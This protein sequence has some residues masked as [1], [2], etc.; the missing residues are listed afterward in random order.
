MTLKLGSRTDPP[1]PVINGA[2]RAGNLTSTS[3][4]VVGVIISMYESRSVLA[5]GLMMGLKFSNAEV[6]LHVRGLVKYRC[7]FN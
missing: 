1:P 4:H 7:W 2:M 3:L 6:S 5:L